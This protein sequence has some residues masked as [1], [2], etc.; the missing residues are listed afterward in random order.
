MAETSYP[1]LDPNIYYIFQLPHHSRVIGYRRFSSLFFFSPLQV[2]YSQ[3]LAPRLFSS[4]PP[5]FSYAP[6]LPLNQLSLLRY[7]RKLFFFSPLQV[8]YS[9]F[10]APRLFSSAPPLFSYAPEL[11]LN[12][13]SLLR[14]LRK[15]FCQR[16]LL[17]LREPINHLQQEPCLHHLDYQITNT[18]NRLS[19][20]RKL[21]KNRPHYFP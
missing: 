5:L 6:E 17:L 15:L 1:T 20:H 8:S 16:F 21:Y 9:Q 18:C 11:P 12:Q 7:L 2:S 13:F 10:L 3:F 14:Y 4:A 19:I